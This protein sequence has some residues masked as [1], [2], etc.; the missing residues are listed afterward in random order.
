MST[1]GNWVE[2]KRHRDRVAAKYAKVQGLT[3]L[4][5]TYE[6]MPEP[7]VDYIRELKVRLRSVENQLRAMAIDPAFDRNAEIL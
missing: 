2:L 6:A 1:S 4:L 5:Q 7:D 3:A